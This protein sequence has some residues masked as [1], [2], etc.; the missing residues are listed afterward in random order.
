MFGANLCDQIFFSTLKSA[1]LL[2]LFWTFFGYKPYPFLETWRSFLRF[3][4]DV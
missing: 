1:F 3:F 4:K 2:Q